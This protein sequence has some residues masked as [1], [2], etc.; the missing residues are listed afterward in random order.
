MSEDKKRSRMY[1]YGERTTMLSVQV[2]AS[3]KDEIRG[4]F[5]EVLKPYE[6]PS[7]LVLEID[8]PPKEIIG[9]DFV[10][11]THANKCFHVEVS[12]L[13]KDKKQISVGLYSGSGKFYTNKVVSGQLKILEWEDVEA[14]KT[15]LQNLNK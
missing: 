6:N 12:A 11:K 15:Y 9:I 13:P 3:K 8:K 2:P 7:A 14:A 5:Y 4:K 10:P 1:I